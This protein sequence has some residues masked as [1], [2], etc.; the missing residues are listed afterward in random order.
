MIEDYFTTEPRPVI[1]RGK[2]VSVFDSSG[3]ALRPWRARGF[4]TVCDPLCRLDEAELERFK[5]RHRDAKFVFACPPLVQLSPGGSRWWESKREIDA[6]FQDREEEAFKKLLDC[7]EDMQVP[8]ACVTP[9]SALIRACVPSKASCVV[10]SPHLWAGYC[11]G[12][13]VLW[14]DIVP[15]NDAYSKRLL[16][17]TRRLKLPATRP[18]QPMIATLMVKGVPKTVCPLLARRTKRFIQAR[19][20]P[21]VG[22]AVALAIANTSV[23]TDN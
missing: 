18:T 6:R 17:T 16:L 8:Y 13:H 7:L 5:A 21:P 2:V 4:T 9:Y 11:S 19:R 1:E 20:A 23:V 10:S 12:P 22:I 14:P 3:L 15:A